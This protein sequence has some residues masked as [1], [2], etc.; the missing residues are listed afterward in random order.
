MVLSRNGALAYTQNDAA[1]LTENTQ[2]SAGGFASAGLVIVDP[3]TVARKVLEKQENKTSFQ[4]VDL[5]L[6]AEFNKGHLPGAL[7]VPYK[8]LGF[9]AE[10][11][12]DLKEDI[13]LYG[14]SE[15]DAVGVD[16]VIRLENK[17]FR[18]VSL[19]AGGI[20]EWKGKKE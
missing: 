20:K 8:K 7:N 3:E 2:R 15:N 10:K 16:A 9:L 1:G 13:I 6:E 19:M 17:G 5:R 18:R 14:Y 11:M 12:F 4:L